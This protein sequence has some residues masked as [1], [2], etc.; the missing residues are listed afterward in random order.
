MA[1]FWHGVQGVLEHFE[2]IEQVEV[3]TNSSKEK[4][5]EEKAFEIGIKS[6][7]DLTP[8]LRDHLTLDLSTVCISK[9]RWLSRRHS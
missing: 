6:I 9:E 1:F 5:Y 3:K 7:K 8:D 2:E 4:N